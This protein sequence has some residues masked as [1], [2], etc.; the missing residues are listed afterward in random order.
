LILPI[1]DHNPR[2][3]FP[4]ATLA[5]V[6]VNAAV[7]LWKRLLLSPE[8]QGELIR[9]AGAIPLEITT[10]TDLPPT[11]LV[12]PPFTILSSMFL[13]DGFLHLIGNMWFLWLFGDNVEDRLGTARFVLFYLVTGV[14]GAVSQC[15]L[16][17]SSPYP[18][19]G[20]SGA[21]AG[22][23]GGYVLLFPRAR[24][25]TLLFFFLRVSV[26]AWVFLGVWFA[27]QLFLGNDSGIAWM[28][29]VG[30]FLGGLGLVRLFATPRP[31]GAVEIEYLP[32]P[33]R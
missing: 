29:H 11:N 13:H 16:M 8:V 17:P 5:L 12:A 10:L 4:A 23:L 32:P 6:L 2:S 25:V 22:I 14:I 28:A 24:I 20:A 7:F 26:P 19:V 18:M 27:A 15:L 3:R 33:R 21:V 1:R 31:I 30:G 9:R